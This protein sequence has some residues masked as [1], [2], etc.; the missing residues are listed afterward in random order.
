MWGKKN[1]YSLSNVVLVWVNVFFFLD[2]LVDKYFPFFFLISGCHIF[3]EFFFI[4]DHSF[5]V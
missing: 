2:Q 4:M 1:L 5:D 3:G